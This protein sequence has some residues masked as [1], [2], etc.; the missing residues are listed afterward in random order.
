M[1]REACGNYSFRLTAVESGPQQP[2]QQPQPVLPQTISSGF[3]GSAFGAA[4]GLPLDP[5]PAAVPRPVVNSGACSLQCLLMACLSDRMCKIV[6]HR[7]KQM[8][9]QNMKQLLGSCA[10]ADFLMREQGPRCEI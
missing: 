2:P 7:C 1:L 6:V 5:L 8:P 3:A 4:A 9:Q 10:R